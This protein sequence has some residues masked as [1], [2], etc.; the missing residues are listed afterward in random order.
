MPRLD[1]DTSTLVVVDLQARLM[2]AIHDGDRVVSETNRLIAGAGLMAVSLC[3]T[4]QNPGG[5]GPTVASID[6]GEAPV[7]P[8]MTFDATAAPGLLDWLPEDRTA[9]VVGC[10]SHVCVLQ[11]VLGLL[12]NGRRVAVVRDAVGSRTAESKAAALERMA[13][14][15]AELVTAEMV[16]FEWAATAEH[17][18][19]REFVRLVK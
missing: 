10:E 12:E 2:P 19:F 4:E 16:L 17:P 9:V 6:L 15:G 1:A 7:F 18:N 14:H 13:D 11:T 3:A 8:K 5:L